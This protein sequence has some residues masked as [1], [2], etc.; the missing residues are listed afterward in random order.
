MKLVIEI[1]H[2]TNSA[3]P[4]PSAAFIQ[5]NRAASWDDNDVDVV[6]VSNFGHHGVLL[7]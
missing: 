3:L 2:S 5:P 7:L 6:P 4:V 1:D